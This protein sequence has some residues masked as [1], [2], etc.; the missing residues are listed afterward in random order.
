MRPRRRRRLR[1]SNAIGGGVDAFSYLSVLLS[2]IIGLAITQVLQG[3]RAMLLA[4][5]RVRPF[6]PTLIWTGLILLI[7]TQSWWSSFGMAHYQDWTFGIFSLILLQTILLYMMAAIVLPDAAPDGGEIDLAAHYQD[8]ITPF[9]G[10]ALALLVTSFVKDLA[11]DGLKT[12]PLD[13]G[14]HGVFAAATIVALRFRGQ[15]THLAVALF[16]AA[17]MIGYV[18][19]LF[20]HLRG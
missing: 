6:A 8:H 4:R 5:R 7:A 20:S 1:R 13:L 14:A 15:R 12:D 9:F 3:Y 18:A 10:I 16:T 11:M 2:I 17:F 19:L